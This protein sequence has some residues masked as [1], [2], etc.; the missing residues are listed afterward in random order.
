MANTAMETK[1]LKSDSEEILVE[2]ELV[3][4]DIIEEPQEARR[5]SPFTYLMTVSTIILCIAILFPIINDQIKLAIQN[6]M[7]NERMNYISERNIPDLELYKGRRIVAVGDLHGI[8]HLNTK[9]KNSILLLMLVTAKSE[10]ACIISNS[11]KIFF[12]KIKFIKD[13]YFEST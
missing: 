9:I 4:K 1:L 13:R 2:K 3:D 12:T 11:D 10:K 5:Y 6:L 8:M 7:P